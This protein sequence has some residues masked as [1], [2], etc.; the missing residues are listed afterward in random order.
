VFRVRQAHELTGLIA[1]AGKDYDQAIAH[2]EQ[3]NQQDPA[4]LY[5]TALAWKAKGEEAKAKALAAQ[6]A[7][8]NVLPLVTYAFVRE[9]AR[10]MS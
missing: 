3:A 7:N 10:R 5:S 4:V 8:A 1:L 9:E 6:A 2:L